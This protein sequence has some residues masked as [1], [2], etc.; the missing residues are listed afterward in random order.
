[1]RRPLIAL[2]ALAA[3]GA[4]CSG[5]SGGA[6]SEPSGPPAQVEGSP[7]MPRDPSARTVEEAAIA[8][9]AARLRVDPS[10]ITV[11]S[12]RQRTW[13]DAS[14]GC[15]QPGG[16]DATG[17]TAGFQVALRHERR[18]YDYRAAPGGVPTLCAAGEDDGG[19]EFV[20]PPGID[21]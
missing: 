16:S 3:L 19:R 20:P 13:P 21:E 14:L 18:V 6:T 8:D 15:P 11:L 17:E 9:L 10:A 4:G 1:M 12:S 5:G 7:A 2:V